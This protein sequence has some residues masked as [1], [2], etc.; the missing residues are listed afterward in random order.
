MYSCYLTDLSLG[1]CMHWVLKTKPLG[2]NGADYL[3]VALFQS[4]N[5]QYQS[6]L[7][8]PLQFVLSWFMSGLLREK[9][10]HPLALVSSWPIW[11]I[12]WLLFCP[13]W[14]MFQSNSVYITLKNNRWRDCNVKDKMPLYLSDSFSCPLNTTTV[15]MALKTS[16]ATDPALAYAFNSFSV[17]DV[18]N[19]I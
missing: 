8:A 9:R 18:I 14:I 6:E 13:N 19:C 7:N 10:L 5:Q 11:I 15:R 2:T 3:Q 12:L 4:P 17:V 1:L 16:S